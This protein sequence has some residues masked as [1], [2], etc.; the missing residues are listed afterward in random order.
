MNSTKGQIYHS[1]LFLSWLKKWK[2]KDD[3]IIIGSLY[4]AVFFIFTAVS[5]NI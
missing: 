5:K 1:F 3:H 4:Y 2:K